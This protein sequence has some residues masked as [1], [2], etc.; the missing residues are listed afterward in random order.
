MQVVASIT[1]LTMVGFSL[2]LMKLALNYATLYSGDMHP[3]RVERLLRTYRWPSLPQAPRKEVL[4][5]IRRL[6]FGLLWGGLLLTP[7]V[8][9]GTVPV[10]VCL[11]GGWYSGGKLFREY[12]LYQQ[13]KLQERSTP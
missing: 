11:I 13:K 12:L 9:I 6:A 5:R 3:K 8:A 1:G 2:H 7:I 10:W 4:T